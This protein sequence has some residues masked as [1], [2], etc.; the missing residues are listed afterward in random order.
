MLGE[1][2]LYAWPVVYGS[3]P[4]HKRYVRFSGDVQ[5][6]INCPVR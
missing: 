3:T 4:E 5:L 6:N 1:F 2:L